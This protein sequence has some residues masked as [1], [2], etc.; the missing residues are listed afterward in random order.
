M[1]PELPHLDKLR[2]IGH[3]AP[4]MCTAGWCSHLLVGAPG[5]V[6]IESIKALVP[7]GAAAELALTLYRS[8]LACAPGRN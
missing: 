5:F 1:S 2:A 7:Q 4:W 3:R 8:G 6:F